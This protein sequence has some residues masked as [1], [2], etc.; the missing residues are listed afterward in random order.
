M[1]EIGDLSKS[2]DSSVTAR[3]AAAAAAGATGNKNWQSV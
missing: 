2:G 3:A 1:E